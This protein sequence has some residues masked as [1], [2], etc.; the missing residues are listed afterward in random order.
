[1]DKPRY[2][3]FISYSHHDAA[4]GRW[5]HRRLENYSL[6]RRLVGRTTSQ[7]ET[8]R[9]LAPIFRDREELAAATSLTDEVRAALAQSRSLVVVCSR[10][11]AASPWVSRE[12]E[13]FRA[14]QPDRPILAVVQEGEPAECFP[15]ALVGVGPP[16]ERIEPLAADFRPGRDGKQLGVLKLIAGIAGLGLD[17]LVQRDAQRRL[18]R[19]MAVTALALAAVLIMG[20]LMIA[21][22]NAR[23][24]AEHQRADAER[25]VEFMLTDLRQ[26]LRSV[27][28][29]D[30][31]TSVN[32]H[33]LDYYKDQDL[34]SLPVPS[35]ERRAHILHLMGADDAARGN[36][37]GALTKLLEARRT[38]ATLLADAPND[39]PR[40]FE[41]AQSEYWVALIAWRSGGHKEAA[42]AGFERYGELVAHLLAINSANPDWQ[43]EAGYAASNLASFELRGMNEPAKAMDNFERALEHFQLALRVKPDDAD[44]PAEIADGYAWLADTQMA[45][46]RF[47]EARA[48]R[49]REAQLLKD[50]LTKDPH[51]A[52]LERELMANA[53]GLA[54][55][56]MAQGAVSRADQR[57]TEA[58]AYASRLSAVDLSDTSLIEEKIAVG[59]FLAKAKLLEQSPDTGRISKLLSDCHAP[60]AQKNQELTDYCA[61]LSVE[62]AAAAHSQDP[63]AVDY[64]RRNR[65]RLNAIRRSRLWGIDFHEECPPQI[66][67]T[68]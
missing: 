41:Q 54:R 46:G 52:D 51:N 24:E 64:L 9:Q 27:G 30:V 21:A 57:L 17:E 28:R 23:R 34:A 13:L 25:L 32:Q 31:M 55:I 7:G 15:S 4:F 35:L 8:P 14:L 11:A 33:A 19:V 58:F 6:P 62:A 49:I 66:C 48:S 44:I 45:L 65:R 20:V 39:P 37:S 47:D 29:L 56:D 2:W 1:V 18:Q 12:V 68:P 43:M 5:L 53:L 42:R 22:V 63:A 38:T 10:E 40:I 61:M 50:L 60:V 26:R 3:A 16:G 36:Y 67:Q 59:L